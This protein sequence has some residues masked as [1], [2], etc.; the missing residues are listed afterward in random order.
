MHWYIYSLKKYFT[1]EGRAGLTEFWQFS[2][3]HLLISIVLFIVCVNP[4]FSAGTLSNLNII[5]KALP[6][7]F[8]IYYIITIPPAFAVQVRRLHDIERSGWFL[9]LNIIPF[10]GTLI[11]LICF[12]R[13]GSAQSN[14]YGPVADC[15]LTPV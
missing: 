10:I 13:Q 15:S 11:L 12:C 9:L 5:Q 2:L 4:V 1:L 3:I 14:Y 6:G 8:F 7:V